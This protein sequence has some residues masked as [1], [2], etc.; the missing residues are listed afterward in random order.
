MKRKEI[1]DLVAEFKVDLCCI[2][3]TK[4]EVMEDRVG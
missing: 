3:E 1:R 4:L 2:Q